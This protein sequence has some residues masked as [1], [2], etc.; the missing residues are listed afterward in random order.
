ME[1]TVRGGE[2]KWSTQHKVK[3]SAV[4][5]IRPHLKYFTFHTSQVD[6]TLNDFIVLHWKG[7]Q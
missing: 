2:V 7:Q 5:D 4:F 1:N 6:G 3:S